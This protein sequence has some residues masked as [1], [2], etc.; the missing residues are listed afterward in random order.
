MGKQKTQRRNKHRT[1]P[2]N[3]RVNAGVQQGVS[4]QNAVQP[5]QVLPV[6]QK[7]SS[8]DATERAWAAAC[9]SNLIMAGQAVRKLLL[10]KGVI[11][12]LLERLTDSNQEVMEESLGALRR[13]IL[14]ILA[15]LLPKISQ[16][17]DLVLK[18]APAVDDEDI[19]RRRTIWDQAENF[20]YIIWSISEAS[21]KHIRAVNRLNVIAFLISFLSAADQIPNRVVVAAGQCL[22][23][24][25]DNNK[26]IYIEFQNNSQYIKMLYDIVDKFKDP[27]MILVRVLACAILVNIREAIQFTEFWDEGDDG[28]SELNKMILPVLVESLNYDIQE[29]VRQVIHAV[30]SGNVAKH[31]ETGEVTPRPKQPLS[32]EEVITNL[33]LYIQS[34]E[35]RLST[36]QLSLE[37]LAD[38]C[39]QD[40]AEDDGWE[41][42]D[43][44]MVDEDEEGWEEEGN[45]AEENIAETADLEQSTT[46]AAV[47]EQLIRSN[48]VVHAFIYQVMPQLI[49]LATLTPLS[50]PSENMLAPTVSDAIALTHQRALECF[51]NFLLAMAEIPSKFWFKEFKADAC[52]GWRWL[53]DLANQVGASPASPAREDVLEVIVTCLWSLGRGLQQDIPVEPSDVASLFGAYHATSS[54]SMR[55]KIVGCLG[56][57]AMR[58]GAIEVNKE[59]GVFFMQVLNNTVSGQTSPAVA[60]EALNCM[61]DVY[62]DCNFDYDE[63]VFIQGG[64][65][66]QLKK[67]VP[68]IRAMVKSVDKRRNFDLRSRS[69]EALIN[70]VAFNKY[71]ETERA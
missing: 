6:V 58:Q 14:T 65:L 49:R 2:L 45:N 20:I 13:D 63:P 34:V 47:N 26:D 24:L 10:S 29:A 5:E 9:I 4:E 62:A 46:S 27:N 21:D 59:I 8:P 43:E 50:F 41:D 64:F 33:Q 61:Y 69:D 71:K 44:N 30:E 16:T 1:N 37:L 42:A 17:I 7:L 70:L 40:D 56:P 28:A 12:L 3:A 55:V 48:P 54:D 36:L 19:G 23:T 31:E 51:N 52:Q 32:K 38:I 35:E 68:T 67:L 11:P 18:K 66:V 60:V 39:V 22:N 25:T 57:I 53:F 15:N